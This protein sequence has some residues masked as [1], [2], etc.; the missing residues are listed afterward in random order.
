MKKIG[1]HI[2]NIFGKFGENKKFL[3]IWNEYK[4]QSDSNEKEMVLLTYLEKNGIYIDKEKIKTITL[5]EL[6]EL[7]KHN[8]SI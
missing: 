1:D 4:K 5:H 8:S 7:L 2:L 6:V 3:T